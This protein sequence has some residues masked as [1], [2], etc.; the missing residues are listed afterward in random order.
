LFAELINL[1][2]LEMAIINIGYLFLNEFIYFLI[3]NYLN[4]TG[5]KYKLWYSIFKNNIGKLL[6]QILWLQ[7]VQDLLEGT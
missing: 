2:K 7:V 1:Y 5:I 3:K 4:N 6:C